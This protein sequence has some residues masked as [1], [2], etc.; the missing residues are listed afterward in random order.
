MR[1]AG[2]T[3]VQGKH[4]EHARRCRQK[5]DR[6]VSNVWYCERHAIQA[7]LKEL[8]QW[9]ARDPKV[10]AKVLLA[11]VVNRD[12]PTKLIDDFRTGKREPL[13]LEEG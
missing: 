8:R 9:D 5:G 6:W 7:E 13:K 2:S 3:F 10:Q 4:G 1:C 11:A 12:F